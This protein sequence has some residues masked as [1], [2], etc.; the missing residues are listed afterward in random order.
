MQKLIDHCPTIM[1]GNNFPFY[2]V[3]HGL[4]YCATCRK[5]MEVRYE[6][7]GRADV[8]HST[9]KK[10]EPIDNAYY[11]FQ[12]YN[13]LGKKLVTIIRLKPVTS[14]TLCCLIL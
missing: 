13:R 14:T 5:S 11:I 4:V 9:K 3:F 12:T 8:D 7:L 10:W 2:N 6:R 1:Q